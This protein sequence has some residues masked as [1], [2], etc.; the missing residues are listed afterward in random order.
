MQSHANGVDIV[1]DEKLL[2]KLFRLSL[3]GLKVKREKGFNKYVDMEA[4]TIVVDI[5]KIR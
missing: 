1:I 2:N 5:D 3:V 4:N